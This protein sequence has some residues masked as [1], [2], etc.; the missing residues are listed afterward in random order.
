MEP[1]KVTKVS[2][3]VVTYK[4]SLDGHQRDAL[5]NEMTDL[6][7]ATDTQLGTKY[8]LLWALIESLIGR[9]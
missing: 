6:V 4:I 5:A 1:I 8:P 7:I 3:S 9:G 2:P